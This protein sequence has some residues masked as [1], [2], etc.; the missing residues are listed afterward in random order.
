[1]HP[2]ANL[3]PTEQRNPLSTELDRLETLDLLRL[4][5]RQDATVALAVAEALPQIAAV[6]ERATTTLSGGGRLFYQG[7]GTSGRLAVL[8]AVELLPTFSAPIGLV[9][10]LLAGGPEALTRSVEGAEDD[11]SLGRRD[12][13]IHAFRSLDM[14]IGLAASGRTPYVL[15]GLRHAAEIGAATAAIVC[16]PGSPMAEAAQIA[17]EI[18]TGPEVLTGSTRLKAGTAQKLVLNMVSTSVMAKLGK[19]YGN[20]MVDVQPT[21]QKLRQRATRIVMEITGADEEMASQWLQEAGWQV[22]V[23]VVMGLANIVASE[24]RQRLRASGGRVREAVEFGN[25]AGNT[26]G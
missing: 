14:L 6:V 3:P 9:I 16:N 25:A 1:M 22:K 21:N 8:D 17:I 19:V 26:G 10:P 18:V 4:V 12:L 2:A 7:A 13:E 20:W 15:G 24:A 23:A 5:N 11:G